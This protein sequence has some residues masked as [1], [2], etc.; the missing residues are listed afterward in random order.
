MIEKQEQAEWDH[1]WRLYVDIKA[2]S[3]E[4]ALRKLSE[5]LYQ[6]AWEA[7][8]AMWIVNNFEY[9]KLIEEGEESWS[10]GNV[11]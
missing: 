1:T 10:I 6:Q 2:P 3:W 11:R 8:L 4:I 9:E 5:E 7:E